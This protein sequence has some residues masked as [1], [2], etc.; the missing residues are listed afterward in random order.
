MER[1]REF[2]ERM[3]DAINLRDFEAFVGGAAP[4]VEF[5]S[6]VAEADG[7][8]YR[9]LEGL[10]EW[11]TEVSQTL[12]GLGFEMEGYAEE[13]D[14]VVI[15]VRVRGN[16]GTTGISQ[17]MWQAAVIRDGKATWWQTFRTEAEAWAA[18]RDRLDRGQ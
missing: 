11:W 4:D 2:A 16:L 17:T 12:G 7:H 3:Y 10:R 5:R 13:G 14:A 15:R 9:G 1:H 6:L 18:A 8:V